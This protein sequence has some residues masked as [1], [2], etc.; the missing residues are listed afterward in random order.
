MEEAEE[1]HVAAQENHVA[2]QLSPLINIEQVSEHKRLFMEWYHDYSKD[3]KNSIVIDQQK[4]NEIIAV[5]SDDSSTHKLKYKYRQRYGLVQFGSSKQLYLKRN[6]HNFKRGNSID[7]ELVTRIAKKEELWGILNECHKE[8]LHG[9]VTKMENKLRTSFCNIPRTVIE[10]YCSLCPL[11]I[12]GNPRISKREGIT[13]IITRGFNMRAQMDLI[14]MDSHPDEDPI[15]NQ[16]MKWIMTYQD[17][18][19][20]FAWLF[21]LPSKQARCVADKLTQIFAMQGAPILLQS[22]NGKEFVNGVL[23][24]LETLWPGLKIF[25][26]RPRH[27]QSQGS[28]EKLNQ[29][30]EKLIHKYMRENPTKGWVSG[31]PIV[32]WTYNTGFHKGIKCTPYKLVYGSKPRL[33]TAS[34]GLPAELLQDVEDEEQLEVVLKEH[35]VEWEAENEVNDKNPAN[36][37]V[38]E[39]DGDDYADGPLVHENPAALE[40]ESNHD[41]TEHVENPA[42]TN[43]SNCDAVVDSESA[44]AKLSSPIVSPNRSRL[45]EEAHQSMKKQGN[46]MAKRMRL[47]A[48]DELLPVGAI[49]LLEAPN[50]DRARLDP[51]Q[52]TA[53]IVQV[54]KRGLYR[55]ATQQGVLKHWY[56][57]QDL[58]FQKQSTPAN[59]GL[60]LVLA[61]YQA[62]PEEVEQ[63]SVTQAVRSQS[64]IGGQGFL[65]CSCK[66][67]CQ[68]GKCKC[69]A[70]GVLCNSRC[71]SS[72]PCQNK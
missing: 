17:H 64:C 35:G 56:Q 47:P 23:K 60:H 8:L 13:P 38:L 34:L 15:S 20:K 1:N 33:G 39:G 49:V 70:A 72:N 26:G 12:E 19:V 51:T 21:A 2:A 53:V 40:T 44:V 54:S 14:Q 10:K 69:K 67:G 25:H 37:A 36:P 32:Q 6:E 24:E 63:L 58:Q 71:H 7:L 22:D 62:V 43:D 59:H 11:C 65:R 5:L 31:L 42:D 18:G 52:F 48:G 55:V 66:G 28:V 30:V 9:R 29:I 45:R 57:R 41:F 46:D 16:Q 4:K 27:S 61:N 3:Q 50:V 68:S